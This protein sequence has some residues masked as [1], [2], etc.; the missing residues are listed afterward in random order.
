MISRPSSLRL[1][2]RFARLAS[3]LGPP[4][5]ADAVGKVTD[6]NTKRVRVLVDACRAARGIIARAAAESKGKARNT[7]VL[8]ARVLSRRKAEQTRREDFTA[9]IDETTTRPSSR[10]RRHRHWRR[11]E[12]GLDRGPIVGAVTQ[13]SQPNWANTWHSQRG[14]FGLT[15]HSRLTVKPIPGTQERTRS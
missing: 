12:K 8:S 15:C 13:D 6:T 1:C 14:L 5:A 4:T 3:P 9:N 10:C 7:S 11:E 2:N